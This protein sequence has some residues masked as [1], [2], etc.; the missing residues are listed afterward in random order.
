MRRTTALHAKAG[1]ADLCSS[2]SL[3]THASPQPVSDK[4]GLQDAD[5]IA[6]HEKHSGG[7]L[8][9]S[10]YP[11]FPDSQNL[12]LTK[13]SILLDPGTAH[14]ASMKNWSMSWRVFA[15]D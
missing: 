13:D 11:R 7:K 10:G 8:M 6:V 5:R 9:A 15:C 4:F 3:H 14:P 2:V 1:A 12:A